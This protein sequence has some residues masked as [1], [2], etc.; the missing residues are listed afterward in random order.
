MRPSG[1]EPGDF[2]ELDIDMIEA[3]RRQRLRFELERVRK[4]LESEIETMLHVNNDGNDLV[5]CDD[6]G[7]VRYRPT[8]NRDGRLIVTNERGSAFL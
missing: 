2:V 7:V 5:L 6:E 8:M 1:T 3:D 4:S